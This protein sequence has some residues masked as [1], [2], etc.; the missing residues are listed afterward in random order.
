M[1]A[2]QRQV[3]EFHDSLIRL[4]EKIGSRLKDALRYLSEGKG[5]PEELREFTFEQI[6]QILEEEEEKTKEFD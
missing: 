3:L 6:R 1:P 5:T 4:T 2:K